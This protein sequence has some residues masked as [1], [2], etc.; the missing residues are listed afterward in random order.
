LIEE[1]EKSLR[2]FFWAGKERAN[3]GQC[4]VAWDQVCKPTEFGGLGIKN[5]RVHGLAL[6]MRWEWLRRTDPDRP[7]QGLPMIRDPGARSTF[8]DLVKIRVGDGQRT[9]FW[10]DKWIN[11]KAA[12]EFAPGLSRTV[13]A[14]TRNSRTV[15]QALTENRWITDV[16]GS[17][18]AQGARECIRLWI[19]V[20]EVS[21][22]TSMADSFAWP[23][24]SDGVYSAKSAYRVL[25]QG[26]TRFELDEAIWKAKATPKSKLFMWLAAQHRI[27]TSDRRARHGLQAHTSACYVCLQE[28]DTAEHILMQCVVAR[29]VWHSCSQ[30]LGVTF[31]APATDSN[32]QEWW[33]TERRRFREKSRKWFD[34]LVCTAGYALWKLRNAWCFRNVQRQFSTKTL[35]ALIVEELIMLRRAHREGVGVLAARERESSLFLFRSPGL[36]CTHRRPILVHILFLPSIKLRYA[37]AYSR[38]KKI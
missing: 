27:W 2:G 26:N 16:S 24:S 7:W 11:G 21:R 3:G 34:G 25:M 38:K 28:E 29:E 37:V 23:W 30:A 8:D 15:A 33:L 10:Q 35:V 17:L 5:L 22:D 31:Q 36:P 32:L 13:S 9:L 12:S 6:R 14:R 4:L 20:N 1:M 18:A 19:A